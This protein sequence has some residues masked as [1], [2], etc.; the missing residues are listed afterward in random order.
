M[1]HADRDLAF[2]DIK[3]VLAKLNGAKIVLVGGQALNFWAEQFLPRVPQLSA[4]APFTSKDID[5][6]GD[7][8]SVV[9]CA[10]RLQGRPLLPKDFDPTPSTGAVI[11]VD[12]EGATRQIDFL[13]RPFGLK[14][15]DVFGTSIPIEAIDD[16]GEPTG[17]VFKVMNPVRCMESRVHNFIGLG[18]NSAHALKQLRVSILCAREFMRDLLEQGYVRDVLKLSKQIYR[19]CNDDIDGRLVQ[20]QSGLDPFDAVLC[21]PPLPGKFITI[22]YPQ[23]RDRLLERRKRQQARLAR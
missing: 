5:F 18:Q 8:A 19:L 11:F 23:M 16:N 4:G 12:E 20:L 7:R 1:K 17:V 22:H 2:R 15:Q 10:K 6:C 21:I 9:D 14:A 13:E 3:N